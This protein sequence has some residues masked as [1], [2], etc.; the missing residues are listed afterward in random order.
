[1]AL[2]NVGTP[3]SWMVYSARPQLDG[4]WAVYGTRWSSSEGPGEAH[5]VSV[6]PTQKQAE[7]SAVLTQRD[8]DITRQG[9]IS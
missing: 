8:Y 7:S 9:F 3:K 4:K 2:R 6:W 1:M 5:L